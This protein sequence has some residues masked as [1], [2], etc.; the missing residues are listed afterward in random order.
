MQNEVL[1]ASNHTSPTNSGGEVRHGLYW[2]VMRYRNHS[3]KLRSRL[4]ET[5]FRIF[6]PYKTI[7]VKRGRKVEKLEIPVLSGYIFIR[8]E[9]ET[10][11]EL[12]K[13]LNLSMMH[14]PFEVDITRPT[15]KDNQNGK[16]KSEQ[17]RFMRVT[18]KAMNPFIRAVNFDCGGVVLLRP[19]D[20]DPEHDDL[21]VFVDGEYKGEMGYLKPGKGT[22]DG[23]VVLT[24]SAEDSD[25]DESSD[26]GESVQLPSGNAVLCYAVPARQRDMKVVAFAPQNRHA[27]DCVRYAR[28][29]ANE[30]FRLYKELGGIPAEMHERMANFVAYYGEA[31]L[32]TNI[33][34]AQHLALLF[35]MLTAME[36]HTEAAALR[37]R[38]EREVIPDLQRRRE[39]ALKRQNAAAAQKSAALL[40]DIRETG[41]V[42]LAASS[43]P[44]PED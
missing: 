24:L 32:D 22:G 17:E 12:A 23:K 39:A 16:K 5:G 20:I 7:E 18:D 28:P 38:L 36:R 2:F 27:K 37:E 35:R 25:G 8:E 21:V 29:V 9:F 3:A 4:E 11:K 26:E 33:Q 14:D 30:A 40:E 19:S 10:V 42:L 43:C 44:D 13:K 1:S 34:K 15:G 6:H 41:E 31:R